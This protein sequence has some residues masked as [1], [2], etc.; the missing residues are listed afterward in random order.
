MT[1]NE[2]LTAFGGFDVVAWTPG[3]PLPDPAT[4]IC[5]LSV[6][7]DEAQSWEEKFSAFLALPGVEATPGLVVGWWSTDD[8][9]TEPTAVVEALVGAHARLPGLQALFFGD[10]TYEENEVSWIMNTD[11][12]PLLAAYPALRHLGVRGGNNLSLGQ[13]DSGHLQT[14]IVQAGGLP[15]NVVREVMNARL[16]NLEHLELYLGTE[17]YGADSSAADLAPL[18]DGHLFPKLSYLGLKNSDHQDEIAQMI[19][20][21]PVLD[22]LHTLDLSLGTLSDDGA[23]ALLGS[24][25]VR[26]LTRLDLR[27]HYCTPEVSA[28]LGELGPEVNLG[29]D[30]NRDDDWRFV[31]LGE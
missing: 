19:A 7:W 22:S 30:Q 17:N 4:T 12:S 14:L 25:R 10:I 11:L 3:E 13:L 28:Q 18:L 31:A 15:V 23:L 27:H 6:E 2:H 1:I 21:A 16:P 5:R 8:T 24:Q 9:E 20:D 26:R 29:D